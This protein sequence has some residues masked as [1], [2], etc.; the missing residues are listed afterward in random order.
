MYALAVILTIRIERLTVQKNLTMT[1][2]KRF[3][4][5]KHIK[6][7]SIDLK[8]KQMRKDVWLE[9]TFYSFRRRVCIRQI[10]PLPEP[11]R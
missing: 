8:K 3:Q 6:G 9:T 2:L 11:P 5:G 10:I 7:C 1:L 4:S